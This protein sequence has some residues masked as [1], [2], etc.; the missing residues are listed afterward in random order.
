MSEIADMVYDDPEKMKLLCVDLKLNLIK[1]AQATV[2]IKAA[3]S[4]KEAVKNIKGDF[5]IRNNFTAAQ[6]QFTPMP[7][8][9]YSIEAIHSIVGVTQKASYMAR[10]EEGGE[11]TPSRGQTLAIPTDVAR[12]GSIRKPVISP[13][14][15][16]K[17]SKRRR[18]RG[19]SSREY[20]SQ[21]AFIVAR[22]FVAFS[23]G[24]FMPFG[25]SGD[26]RNLHEV[27]SFERSDDKAHFETM[28]VYKFEMEKT[29]TQPQPW[30]LPAC[31]K[32]DVDSQDI[33]NS[34]AK[35]LGL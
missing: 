29:I 24:L 26:Q 32:V 28:Q 27:N 25:G 10:Q 2:N 4:R 22:A 7:E 33:F 23:E 17:I 21:K 5:I 30:L 11:Q 34:Q 18:V 6:V 12:G 19:Q 14:R 8:G 15:V 16:G 3:L 31:E 13:M 20:K 1:A 9:R 35:K